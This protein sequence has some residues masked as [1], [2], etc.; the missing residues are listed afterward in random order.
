[1]KSEFGGVGVGRLPSVIYLGRSE[2]KLA[3]DDAL[4]EIGPVALEALQQMRRG[5]EGRKPRIIS[6]A[7]TEP[8]RR[9]V[10]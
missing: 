8:P 10:E 7:F 4:G 2:R 5:E 3:L 6:R 1:M 9:Q